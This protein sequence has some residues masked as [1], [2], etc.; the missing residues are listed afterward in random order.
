VFA[1]FGS[2][3]SA[4]VATAFLGLGAGALA[5]P[6][7]LA[8]NYGLPVDDATGIA[9]VRGLGMR[10][11]VLGLIVVVFLARRERAALASTIGLSALVGASDFTLVA[12]TRGAE[13]PK[14]SLAIHG[15]GTIGL[16]AIWAILRAEA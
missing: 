12:T 3:L 13:A 1:S 9:Y 4:L 14:A 10:D 6:L 2:F 7:E 8:K 5:A 16:L 11:A 15:I